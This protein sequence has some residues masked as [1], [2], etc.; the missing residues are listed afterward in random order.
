MGWVSV[1]LGCNAI[2]GVPSSF[3]SAGGGGAGATA[4]ATTT[5]A[6]T[7][8]S[9]TASATGTTS[10]SS[11]GGG[12]GA[13]ALVEA[14]AVARWVADDI[15][16]PDQSVV[17]VW[18]DR[19]NDYDLT[20]LDGAPHLRVGAVGGH[21]AVA[22]VATYDPMGEITGGDVFERLPIG[23]PDIDQFGGE[24]D[25]ILTMTAVTRSFARPPV[26]FR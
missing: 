15:A 23:Q 24:P 5:T 10:T 21:N 13:C 11:S 19:A 3:E 4:T 17:T 6:T 8:T 16:G 12:G 1:L 25:P 26:R 22:F 14:D 20:V 2:V 18:P 9:T 7:A